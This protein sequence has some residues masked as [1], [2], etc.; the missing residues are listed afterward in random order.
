M[1][2]FWH[3]AHGEGR[4]SEAGREGQGWEGPTRPRSAV[5]LPP[6]TVC[7]CVCEFKVSGGTFCSHPGE[8]PPTLPTVHCRSPFR[9]RC[10][11]C[12]CRMRHISFLH[13]PLEKRGEDKPALAALPLGAMSGPGA[14]ARP[15]LPR[16]LVFRGGAP[17]AARYLP[18][19]QGSSARRGAVSRAAATHAAGALQRERRGGVR[20]AGRVRAWARGGAAAA[21]RRRGVPGSGGVTAA[22]AGPA[23]QH[24]ACLQT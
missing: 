12:T 10:S 4:D 14:G 21:P 24:A 15:S 18:D 8:C 20:G 5:S 17:C 7:G 19:S 2:P 3:K 1:A 6:D 13:E 9:S 22:G 16:P 11:Y 23:Q